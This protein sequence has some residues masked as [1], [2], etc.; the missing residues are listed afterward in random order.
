M[1][2]LRPVP[3]H[4]LLAAEFRAWMLDEKGW[5]RLTRQDR[6]TYAEAADRFTCGRF[7]T[8]LARAERRHVLAFISRA[9]HPGT[10]NHRLHA[11][12]A[13]FRF[14]IEHG[15]RRDDPTAGIEQVRQPRYLPRPISQEHAADLLQAAGPISPRTRA[16]VGLLL[17]SG[18]RR[19]EAAGLRWGDVDYR[20]K[21]LRVLGKGSKERVIPMSQALVDVLLAWRPHSPDAGWVFPSPDP[22]DSRHIPPLALWK[23]VVTAGEAIGLRVSP[24]MLRHTFAT[25][26]LSNRVDI[27]HVQEL[28]GH[29]SLTS[30][31]IYTGVVIEH[32]EEDVAQ[33]NFSAQRG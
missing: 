7:E 28:L 32:L 30:T 22:R 24:H 1:K 8:R 33:L 23:D 15:Y 4:V 11:L 2:P 12:R 13:F 27:R 6:A 25:E 29:A 16:I 17:Y 3:S 9:Q 18:L 10:R 31:Q 21:R 19:S 26:L 5:A 20:T 14:L